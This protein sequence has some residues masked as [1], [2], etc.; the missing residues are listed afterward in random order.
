MHE[1]NAELT[2]QLLQTVVSALHSIHAQA[3]IWEESHTVVFTRSQE[4]FHN[5]IETIVADGTK[6]HKTVLI[7]LIS[8]SDVI[9]WS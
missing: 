8:G 7:E 9:G 5:A 1:L 4:S 6:R 2:Q 3:S